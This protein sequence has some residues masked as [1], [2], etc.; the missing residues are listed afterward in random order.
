[1][2]WSRHQRF[3]A[4]EST[5]S[6]V[7]SGYMLAYGLAPAPAGQLGDRYGHKP[8]FIIGLILFTLTSVA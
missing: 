2:T 3:E 4:S 7:L 5:L 1:M 6:W 8:V